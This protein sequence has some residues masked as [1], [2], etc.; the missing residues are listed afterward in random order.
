METGRS[1]ELVGQPASPLGKPQAIE[2]WRV[3]RTAREAASDLLTAMH[4]HT[5]V[6]THTCTHTQTQRHT[7]T[8]M[9]ARADS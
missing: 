2:G 8:H 9:R 7:H 5:H 3:L 4:T 6:H 1:S